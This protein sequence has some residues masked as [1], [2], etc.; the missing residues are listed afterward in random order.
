MAKKTAKPSKPS[1]PS[2]HHESKPSDAHEEP[3]EDHPKAT[4]ETFRI[5]KVSYTVLEKAP[6]GV[7]HLRYIFPTVHRDGSQDHRDF[8]YDPEIKRK[9]DRSPEGKWV[10][11]KGILPGSSLGP[12]KGTEKAKV[13]P[14]PT[15]RAAPR[16]PVQ[17][18]AEAIRL[19]NKAMAL[20]D[21]WV[22]LS[23]SGSRDEAVSKVLIEHLGREIEKLRAGRD[24]ISKMDMETLSNLA[25]LT[26]DELR[27]L[28][29]TAKKG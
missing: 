14:S 15:R 3:R 27:K 6:E 25:Q 1:D 8:F 4:E 12:R 2:H 9:V 18:D 10:P 22:V 20:V 21:E 26:P 28:L 11:A 17:Q 24:L 5:G 16:T 13:R 23:C 19:S 29:S 7:L